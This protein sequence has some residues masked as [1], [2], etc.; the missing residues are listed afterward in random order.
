MG[1]GEGGIA[2]DLRKSVVVVTSNQRFLPS[3]V[4]S[5]GTGAGEQPINSA[6]YKETSKQSE[7]LDQPLP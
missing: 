6:A 4:M 1:E 3:A 5:G 7:T 2:I